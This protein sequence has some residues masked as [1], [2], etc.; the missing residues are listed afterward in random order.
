M[1]NNFFLKKR[2][3]LPD[4]E[5]MMSCLSSAAKVTS[6]RSGISVHVPLIATKMNDVLSPQTLRRM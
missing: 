5:N 4:S 2:R 3:F 1:D 6:C